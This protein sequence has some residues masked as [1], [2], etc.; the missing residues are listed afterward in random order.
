MPTLAE[1]PKG[2]SADHEV[3]WSPDIHRATIAFAEGQ[4][5]A[6]IG[7]LNGGIY[8]VRCELV[9]V[10]HGQLILFDEARDVLAQTLR[11][12]SPRL[13]HAGGATAGGLLC[14]DIWDGGLLQFL[15]DH[16]L[17]LEWARTL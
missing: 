3:G 4:L 12:P 16:F 5:H 2:W 14:V 13:I 1:G 7:L 15:G 8:V 11:Y 9:S 17:E 6:R 10:S